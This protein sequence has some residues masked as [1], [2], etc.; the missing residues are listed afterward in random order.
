[1]S[2][3][4]IYLAEEIYSDQGALGGDLYVRITQQKRDIYLFIGELRK[5]PKLTISR[6]E[7]RL[8]PGILR[9]D[10]DE[11]LYIDDDRY[12]INE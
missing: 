12:V 1:M 10:T 11:V 4:N 7:Y 8:G 2:P 5:N 9:W 6:E 3:N